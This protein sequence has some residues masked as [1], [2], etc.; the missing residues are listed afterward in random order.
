MRSNIDRRNFEVLAKELNKYEKEPSK[1]IVQLINPESYV[2]EMEAKPNF[3][4]QILVVLPH[5][6][7]QKSLF[8][9]LLTT[10]HLL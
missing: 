6:I 1:L 10:G 7:K 4:Y 2:L 9:F 8:L 5:P 3:D